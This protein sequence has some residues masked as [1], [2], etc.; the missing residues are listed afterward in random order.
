MVYPLDP[1]CG[2]TAE[3]RTCV[4]CQEAQNGYV[5]FFGYREALIR[6]LD[7]WGKIVDQV[8]SID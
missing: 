6:P 4:E 2:K 8:Q 3:H 7:I 1:G 5:E